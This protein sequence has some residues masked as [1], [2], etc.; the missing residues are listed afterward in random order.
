M[1]WLNDPI[2]NQYTDPEFACIVRICPSKDFCRSYF[3]F[4]LYS[5]K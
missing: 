1:M 5:D 2:N 4:V 3:C